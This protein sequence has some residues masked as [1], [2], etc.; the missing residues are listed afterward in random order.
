MPF[1]SQSGFEYSMYIGS[2]R[3]AINAK[4]RLDTTALA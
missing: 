1:K 4:V 3:I 2:D